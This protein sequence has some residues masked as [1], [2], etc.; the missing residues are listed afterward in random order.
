MKIYL[1]S[2]LKDLEP[3]RA[4]VREVLD[5]D[6]VRDSYRAHEGDL[7]GS[8]L[9]DVAECD[10]YV[11]LI[12]LRYGFVPPNEVKSITQLEYEEARRLKKDRLIFMKD[13]KAVQASNTDALTGEHPKERINE[14]RSQLAGGGRDETRP[15]LFTDLGSLKVAVLKAVSEL[16]ARKGGGR[17]L[18][19]GAVSHPWEIKYDL[20][21]LYAPGTDDAIKD[22][23]SLCDTNGS[24]VRFVPLSPSAPEQCLPTLDDAVRRSRAIT[25][26]VTPPSLSRFKE[27]ISALTSAF[28]LVRHRCDAMLILSIDLPSDALPS[29][30]ASIVDGCRPTQTSDWTSVV[31]DATFEQI[32]RWQRQQS[33]VATSPT[34]IGLPYLTLA[35]TQEEAAELCERPEKTFARFGDEAAAFRRSRFDM[36]RARISDIAPGWPEGFY[37]EDRDAWRPFGPSAPTAAEFVRLSASKVN[38]TPEGSR[39]RRLLRETHLVPYRYRLHE[40]LNDRFGS[41]EQ[42]RRLTE[43]GCLILV[44]EFALLHPDVRPAIDT[45]LASNNAAVVSLSGCDPSHSPLR[46]LLAETSH[47]RVGNLLARF[48]EQE[49]LRC[50]LGVNSIERLQRWLR[51]VLPELMITLGQ[52]Q[53]DPALV[54]NAEELLTK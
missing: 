2:T 19:R 27:Q 9:H 20:S 40:Y 36:L 41:R 37:G 17:A 49:D 42:L 45:L 24:R 8:C 25:L 31:R 18:M 34:L 28:S 30:I 23:L 7:T 50:E 5:R 53:G 52:R 35:L 54:R 44:D 51:G 29:S 33:A 10:V 4:A 6:E 22:T 26:I 46:S 13:P 15:A 39:E 38:S 47:L 12:G 48:N 3:E 43:T 32:L 16:R 14:F 11:G 21:I 1:S